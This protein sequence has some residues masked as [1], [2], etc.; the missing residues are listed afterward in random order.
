MYLLIEKT[1]DN[2]HDDYALKSDFNLHK[3]YSTFFVH[4]GGRS[5]VINTQLAMIVHMMT[6]LNNLQAVVKETL[7]WLWKW[8]LCGQYIHVTLVHKR[9]VY[10]RRHEHLKDMSGSK[11]LLIFFWEG[12]RDSRGTRQGRRWSGRC[13]YLCLILWKSEKR[14]HVIIIQLNLN[15]I[16]YR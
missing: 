14:K 8:N 7:V 16:L 6:T 5:C 12:W 15:P 11:S 3:T 13:N 2:M 4:S 9:Q 10:C 1:N